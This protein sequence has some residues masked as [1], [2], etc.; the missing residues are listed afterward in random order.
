MEPKVSI[1]IPIYNAEKFI[2]ETI[3]SVLAQTYQDFEIVIT[4]NCSTDGSA[5]IIQSFNDPRIRYMKNDSNIGAE[6][7]WNKVLTLANGSYVK[8]LCAD[9]VIYPTCL[10]EQVAVLDNPRNANVVLV[11][12]HKEVINQDGKLVMTRKYPGKKGHINGLAALRKS[13]RR[14]TNIIG[15]PVAG[16]FRR[17]I[18]QKSGYYNGDNLYMID[19][20]LWSR[21]LK[22]GDLYVIDKV[23][24]AF[25][26]STQ[27]LSTNIGFGQVKL[28]NTFV[29][30]LF[31]DKS[32]NIS[33][34]DKAMAKTMALAMGI[35]RNMIYVIYFRKK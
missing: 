6:G 19:I 14:G 30:K 7:N 17:E 16:L 31:A 34:F 21:M 28:F 11:T 24:Y 32:F 27:S 35:A 22:F 8:L 29:D 13:L 25:R 18:L 1:C 2:H 5:A 23:L 15:E 20:D 10:E 33:I 9:D 26:I 4:D 3:A 12:S